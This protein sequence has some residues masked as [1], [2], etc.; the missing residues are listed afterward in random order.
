MDLQICHL[1]YSCRWIGYTKAVLH[2]DI[3]HANFRNPSALLHLHFD[4]P[5][6]MNQGFKLKL[7]WWNIL[8]FC[9]FLFRSVEPGCRP[10]E[11]LTFFL[12]VAQIHCKPHLLIQWASSWFAIYSSLLFFGR[13]VSLVIWRFYSGQYSK[14]YVSSPYYHSFR[15]A[16][17]ISG[18][19]IIV[20]PSSH[21]SG[22][23][24]TF[25]CRLSPFEDHLLKCDKWLL[26]PSS[27]PLQSSQ[28]LI[29]GVFPK[30]DAPPF[31]QLSSLMDP[32][33]PEGVMPINLSWK[34]GTHLSYRSYDAKKLSLF[35][36][37]NSDAS[38]NLASVNHHSQVLDN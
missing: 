30:I 13:G 17:E 34:G 10:F 27:T 33:L 32:R 37:H 5:M 36:S 31:V 12:L 28:D 24:G 19:S 4:P 23:S 2:S 3:W 29:V 11:Y 35:G 14:T 21:L 20:V 18:T 8:F 15:S 7:S 38:W 1:R 26:W 9:K 22:L 16:H 25:S 6:A